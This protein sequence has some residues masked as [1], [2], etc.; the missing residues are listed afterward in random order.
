[1]QASR[2]RAQS[3]A[4]LSPPQSPSPSPTAAR[5]RVGSVGSRV[6]CGACEIASRRLLLR[7]EPWL[8]LLRW[9]L[10]ADA[11]RAPLR[12]PSVG[13]GSASL[14]APARRGAGARAGSGPGQ[15]LSR[16]FSTVQ[17][18]RFRTPIDSRGLIR[19]SKILHG[20]ANHPWSTPGRALRCGRPSAD[21]RAE[22]AIWPQESGGR[23]GG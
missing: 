8:P 22:L 23:S 16:T 18:G 11:P 12:A 10:F 3:Q 13:S 2:H 17:A 9:A 4:R 15:V 21:G 14:S 19:R 5:A 20:R 7:L 6:A 1:M